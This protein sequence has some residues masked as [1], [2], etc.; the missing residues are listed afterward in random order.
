[1]RVEARWANTFMAFRSQP[2]LFHMLVSVGSA[3][4][5]GVITL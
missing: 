3:R 1:M 4:L 2:I 5:Q